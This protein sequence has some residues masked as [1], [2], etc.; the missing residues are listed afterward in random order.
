MGKGGWIIEHLGEVLSLIVIVIGNIVGYTKLI[1]NSDS[2]T[3]RIESLE[4]KFSD[5]HNNNQAH[6]TP[7]FERRLEDLHNTLEEIKID[8]KTLLKQEK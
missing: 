7:D 2:H 6:R 1:F 4:S 5:H 8:I 3:K